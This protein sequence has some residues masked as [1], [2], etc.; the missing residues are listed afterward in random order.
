MYLQ[1]LRYPCCKD[2]QHA[3]YAICA[4]DK[5]Q[6]VL[7]CPVET[8]NPKD[9]LNIYIISVFLLFVLTVCHRKQRPVNVFSEH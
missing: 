5:I 1:Q 8:V 9:V 4:L 2:T 6:C 3:K 7:P